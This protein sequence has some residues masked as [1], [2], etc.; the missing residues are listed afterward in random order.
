MV[1]LGMV[2]PSLK[3]LLMGENL[4]DVWK[5]LNTSKKTSWSKMRDEETYYDVEKAIELA[6]EGK[7]VI[8]FYQYLK[9]KKI[10]KSEVDEF[11]GSSTAAEISD[12]V[13]ELEEYIKGG[14][15]NEHKQIREGY[16]H[17]PKPQAR[18]IR[19]YLYKILEDAWRYSRDK[20]PGRRKK[21]SK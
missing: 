3:L 11:I 8:D 13:L 15:D 1:S 5:R 9:V 19:N 21:T 16:H 14:T 2:L 17:I 18:K 20:R 12:V 7:F 4:V 10:L 6:F